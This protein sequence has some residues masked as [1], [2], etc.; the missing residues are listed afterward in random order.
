MKNYNNFFFFFMIVFFL[1]FFAV[2]LEK[3]ETHKN[4]SPIVRV[5]KELEVKEADGNEVF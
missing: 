4:D 2:F 3:E 5:I 1:G